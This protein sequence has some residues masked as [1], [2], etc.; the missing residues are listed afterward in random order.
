VDQF[1][2]LSVPTI[3]AISPAQGS[4]A[5][6]AAVVIS[7]SGL[8]DVTKVT[9]GG[10]AAQFQVNANGTITAYAPAHAKGRVYV[11]VTSAGGTSDKTADDLFT[12]S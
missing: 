4:T 9:F 10:V 5:G 3:I 11:V 8:N 12:Y 7:G 1:T 6:G 2:Y